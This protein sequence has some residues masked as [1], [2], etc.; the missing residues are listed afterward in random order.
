MVAM[1]LQDSYFYIPILL[2][3]QHYLQFMVQQEHFQFAVLTFGL[4]SALW[5]FMNVMV[6]PYLRRAGVAVFS[7]LSS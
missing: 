4:T 1:D 5:W 3:H 2:A 7:Y 6:A